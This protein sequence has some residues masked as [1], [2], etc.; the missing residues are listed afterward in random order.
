MIE[1][2]YSDKKHKRLVFL[3]ILTDILWIICFLVGGFVF[4][5]NRQGYVI[6]FSLLVVVLLYQVNYLCRASLE[7][8]MYPTKIKFRMTVYVSRLTYGCI[9]YTYRLSAL[10]LLSGIIFAVFGRVFSNPHIVEPYAPVLIVAGIIFNVLLR[11]KYI[12]F[13]PNDKAED[14]FEKFG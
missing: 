6:L 8:E 2:M 7:S 9:S 14:T 4:W 1:T 12:S 5:L 13:L 10:V 11:F 3:L